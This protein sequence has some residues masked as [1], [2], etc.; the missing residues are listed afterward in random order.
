MVICASA[1]NIRLP[2]LA[3]RKMKAAPEISKLARDNAVAIRNA[4]H[5]TGQNR[6]AALVGVHETSISRW[7]DARPDEVAAILAACGLKVVPKDAPF[8][9][10]DHHLALLT[11]A[12]IGLESGPHNGF[13]T[14]LPH[15]QQPDIPLDDL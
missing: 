1:R 2:P 10:V 12:R 15:A 3:A 11:L 14:P 7:K 8:L 5:M 9:A 6:V 4:L 13:S